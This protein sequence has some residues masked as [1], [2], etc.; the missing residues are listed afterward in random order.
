MLDSIP[1]VHTTWGEW[2]QLHPETDVLAVPED[3][4]HRDPR[5]GHGSEEYWERPGLDQLFIH[6]LYKGDLDRQ[7]PENVMVIGVNVLGG[8]RAYPIT[9]IKLEGGLINDDLGG[10]PIVV[11]AGPA[12]ESFYTGAFERQVGGRVLEFE[13]Q[14]DK[15]VDKETGTHWNVEGLAVEG[16]LKGT[17][18]QYVH[19]AFTRWHS[20]IYPHPKTE[21]YRTQRT[22]APNVEAGIFESILEGFRE[23]LHNVR[24]ER[25]LL[26]LQRPLQSDKG[27]VIRIGDDRFLLHHFTSQTAARDYAH[28]TKGA[29]RA[30]LYV[31]QSDPQKQF[32]DIGLNNSLLPD[33]D[34]KW[35]KLVEDEDF[36]GRFERS[37]PTEDLR[38]DYP[39]FS[40]IVA[41]LNENGFDCFPGAPEMHTDI[42][43]W[44]PWGTYVG[45]RPNEENSFVVTV[46]TSDPFEIHRF[47]TVEAAEEFQRFV[48]HAIRVGR[49]V[50]YSTPLNRFHLP[51]FRMVDKPDEKVDWSEFL[52]DEE[53]KEVLRSVIKD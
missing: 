43:D 33:E 11:I 44:S 41:A 1:V 24:V 5:G 38:E 23:A 12:P 35:S 34:I 32:A 47:K 7:L 26:N 31:L 40:E 37:V 3:P 25:E 14:G 50:F 22:E 21:I 29:V 52:E 30:G 18:L 9:D 27:L 53:F 20:W 42:V 10:L 36:V 2:R 45:L 19:F 46:D 51:R 17:Q 15:L 49:Y 16:E 28:F 48:K 13:P 4:K 6:S 8:V 39:G